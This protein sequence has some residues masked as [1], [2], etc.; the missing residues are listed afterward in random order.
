MLQNL[1]TSY[2]QKKTLNSYAGP[3]KALIDALVQA[4]DKATESIKTRYSNITNSGSITVLTGRTMGTGG[5]RANLPVVCTREY[6]PVCGIVPGR[7]Y[8]SDGV[9]YP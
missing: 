5:I 7:S 6:A 1:R 4:I 8:C 3:R 9:C 2:E